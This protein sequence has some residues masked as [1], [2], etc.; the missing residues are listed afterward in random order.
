MPR[1][2][3]LKPEP[4]RPS[5]P[6]LRKCL[7][8]A[9]EFLSEYVGEHICLMCKVKKGWCW[10]GE[11]RYPGIGLY[12]PWPYS[13]CP[14]GL[15]NGDKQLD[16]PGIIGRWLCWLGFHDFKV[17]EATLGF[18]EAGSVEKV[19]CRRCRLIFTRQT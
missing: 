11:P 7:K 16:I 2:S 13:L 18:G 19:K 6:K 15:E 4:D 1:G 5:E 9:K 10:G 17:L 8:C 14:P 12:S 3:K